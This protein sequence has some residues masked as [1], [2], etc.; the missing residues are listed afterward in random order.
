MIRAWWNRITG[1]ALAEAN[2]HIAELLNA[3]GEEVRHSEDLYE[4]LQLARERLADAEEKIEADHIHILK[5]RGALTR[6]KADRSRLRD[7]LR[8][9]I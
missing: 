3:H 5:L 9:L 1:Q 7:Q 2:A 4:Q 6:V 8:E